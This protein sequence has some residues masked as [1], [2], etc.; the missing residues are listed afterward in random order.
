M[1]AKKDIIICCVHIPTLPFYGKLA[2]CSIFIYLMN[3]AAG[4]SKGLHIIRHRKIEACT[5]RTKADWRFIEQTLK[6]CAIRVDLIEAIHSGKDK[7]AAKWNEFANIGC[8]HR[9]ILSSNIC[10]YQFIPRYIGHVR[11]ADEQITALS[12]NMGCKVCAICTYAANR[13]GKSTYKIHSIIYYVEIIGQFI[14]K[15][16]WSPIFIE[17]VKR[18][19]TSV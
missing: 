13:P 11:L 1:I 19:V 8:K 3:S 5:V 14:G 15:L 16:R 2:D 9:R 7:R 12:L 6:F 18:I 17:L 4:L 10:Y